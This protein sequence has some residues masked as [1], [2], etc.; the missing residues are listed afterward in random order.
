MR[1]ALL[2]LLA[3][4]TRGFLRPPPRRMT[5]PMRAGE[6]FDGAEA[7]VADQIAAIAPQ[8]ASASATA[9]ELAALPGAK[10]A[11]AAGAGAGAMALAGYQLFSRFEAESPPDDPLGADGR[12]APDAAAL[13]FARRPAETLQRALAIA[14]R[15]GGLGGALL[16][17]FLSGSLETNEAERAAALTDA[18]VDLGP[19][20]I[21][22]GQALSIRS[23]LLRPAYCDALT[24]LQDACPPFDDAEAKR[25]IAKELGAPLG[26]LF[27]DIGAAPIA[28]ASLGQVYVARANVEGETT[29]VAVK[30]QRPGVTETIA[31]DL[32][33]LRVAAGPLRAAFNLNTDL[34]GIVDAWGVRFV[35][36]L[37]YEREAGHARQFSTSIAETPLSGAVFAPEPLSQLTTRKVL[38][39][40]W[41]EGKRLDHVADAS[42]EGEA[43]RR[44]K[45]AALCGVAMNAYLTMMLETG[46]LHADPHP[47]NLIVE[48]DTGKL[49]ILDWG[50]V[51]EMDPELRIAYIEHIAHLVAKDYAS[52]PADLVAL[53]FV[54]E[55]YEEAIAGSDAVEVLS[56]V[57][58]Q[59]AGGGGA[60]KID[61]PE[62]LG[63]MRALANRQGNLFRLPPYFAYIARAFSVLE[64]IGLRN[65]PDYAIVGE[66]LPYISQ[67][68]LSDPS[69]RVAKALETFV[70]GAEAHEE[71]PAPRRMDADRLSYLVDGLQSYTAA[72]SAAQHLE[73]TSDVADDALEI[74]RKVADLLLVDAGDA[75]PLQSIVEAELAKALGAAARASFAR[76]RDSQMGTIAMTAV[77]PFGILD[78]LLKSRLVAPDRQDRLQL[79][80]LSRVAGKAGGELGTAVEALAALDADAQRDALAELGDLLWKNRAGA[81]KAARRVAA[82]LLEQGV[83]RVAP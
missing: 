30:V 40:T 69:P 3:G 44:K 58:T 20:F 38:T 12:Y 15:A 64:G 23:D 54:P 49:A 1:A 13:Y 5:S 2:V 55:G 24:T 36:E 79:A 71:D 76:A 8:L 29:K 75:T 28:S 50:L 19:T 14:G 83:E 72:E 56:D 17:D 42:A 61:V 80:T 81:S 11:A 43:R 16:L 52:V 26:S 9:A 67:R 53:G 70:Y 68:L 63:E 59:F 78:P 4:A 66:C 37:D 22:V 7:L 18:L 51:T 74:A 35:D 65:D 60:A 34:V 45:V 31:L 39:T 77:D 27:E 46:V 41:V 48:D 32:H 62:V 10:A 25:V 73:D 21:K 47:G 82:N 33:L 57:Y 6:L